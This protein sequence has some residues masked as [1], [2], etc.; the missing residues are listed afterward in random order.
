M[1]SLESLPNELWWA[2]ASSLEIE[3]VI[4]LSRTSRRLYQYVFSDQVSRAVAQVSDILVVETLVLLCL[5]LTFSWKVQNTIKQRIR[6]GDTKRHE[7][8]ASLA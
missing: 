3:D 6:Q 8:G 4:S 1:N 5:L 7:L 2:I